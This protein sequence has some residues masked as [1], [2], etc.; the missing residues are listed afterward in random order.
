[1]S[2]DGGARIGE[3]IGV[4]KGRGGQRR[5]YEERQLKLKAIQSIIRKPNAVETF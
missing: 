1:M 3:I 4:R 5:K 2:R